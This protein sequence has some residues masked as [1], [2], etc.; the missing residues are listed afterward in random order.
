ME[1]YK[2]LG[3]LIVDEQYYNP[4]PVDTLLLDPNND[5]HEI[6]EGRLRE[7]HKR[8]DK[9]INDMRIDR[10]SMYAYLLS[11]LSKESVDELHGH[12]DWS[13]IEAS[14]D[15]LS[16][17]KIIKECHQTLTTSKVALVIKKTAREEYVSCCQGLYES[18]V[19]YKRQ[20]DARLDAYKESGNQELTAED[21]GMDF[22]YGLDNCR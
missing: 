17:W 19:D 7:V 2:N 20:F 11:K 9:E 4:P 1:K 5:P 12:K 6:E 3:S 13:T 14:R 21:I 15:P 8:R 10:I 18:I 22:L 16:L